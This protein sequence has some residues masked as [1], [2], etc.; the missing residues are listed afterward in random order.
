MASTAAGPALEG[1]NI[2]CG[3]GSIAGAVSG[4]A[5]DALGAPHIQTIGDAAPVGLCGTGLIEVVAA[6]VERGIIDTTGKLAEPY[7]STGYTIAKRA[8]GTDFTLT[9]KDIR[10]LQMAKG[11]IRAGIETLLRSASCSYDDI[12]MVYLAGGFGYFLKPEKAASIGLLPQEWMKK[13]KSVGNTSLLGA[14]DV[15]YDSSALG[16]I[17]GLCGTVQEEVLG[18]S[19]AFQ[20]LYIHYMEFPTGGGNRS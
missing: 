8:D 1:G 2:S 5:F 13:T 7:F 4:F 11:A 16:Q 12:G 3:V 20:N 17:Q 14:C 18:N 10:E 19:E 15:L 9:Q 6:L